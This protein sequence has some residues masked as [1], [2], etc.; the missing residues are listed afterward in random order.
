MT[1]GSTLTSWFNIFCFMH[2]LAVCIKIC[3]ILS[4]K[5]T[6][7]SF[8][9]GNK[10]LPRNFQ[11]SLCMSCTLCP[12]WQQAEELEIQVLNISK[13]VLGAEHPHTLTAMTN[14]ASTFWNQGRW[15]QAEELQIQVLDIRKRVLGAEH[16]DTLTAMVNLASTFWNQRRWQQA[17]ELEIQVLD[18]SKRV[19]GAEHPETLMAMENLASTFGNQERWQQAVELE[20]Q[21]LDIRKRVLGADHLGVG[22]GDSR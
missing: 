16:P 3:I 18:I 2:T 17:E 6:M 7:P 10:M 15:Q 19:L 11:H 14:L 9:K 5:H 20:I 1:I 13:R 22:K 4:P 8:K 21:V 12:R